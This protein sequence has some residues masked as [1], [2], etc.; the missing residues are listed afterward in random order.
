MG[1]KAAVRLHQERVQAAIE[2][3]KDPRNKTDSQAFE[4]LISRRLNIALA[5]KMNGLKKATF[6]KCG[7]DDKG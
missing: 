4:Q 1:F 6:W 7:R 3:L 2:L 5:M